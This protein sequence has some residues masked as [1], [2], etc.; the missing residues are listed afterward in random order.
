MNAVDP[1]AVKIGE[2]GKVLPG[3]EPARFETPHLACRGR[4]SRGRLAAD[5]W[6]A[7]GSPC[8]LIQITLCTKPWRSVPNMYSGPRLFILHIPK[9]QQTG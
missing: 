7:G 6:S 2:R 8:E 3:T 4:A 9:G 5:T 1:L